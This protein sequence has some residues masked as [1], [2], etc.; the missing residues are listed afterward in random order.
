VQFV[1][2]VICNVFQNVAEPLLRIDIVESA[3]GKE[4]DTVPTKDTVPTIVG[5]VSA[6]AI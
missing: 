3:A 4:A 6:G 2:F 5:T 1:D